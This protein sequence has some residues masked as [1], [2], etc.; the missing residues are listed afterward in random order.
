METSHVKETPHLITEW[1]ES[2]TLISSGPGR[3]LI[4]WGKRRWLKAPSTDAATPSF[5]FPDFF[6][7]TKSP[8]FVHEYFKEISL[9]EL[10]KGLLREMK[11]QSK[12]YKWVN[13]YQPLF[14]KTFHTL[15]QKF[16]AREI[17][18]A[19]PF[20]YE[21]TQTPM[22]K[23]QR[24]QSLVSVLNYCMVNPAYLYGF[25]DE[26]EGILGA[27]PEILFRYSDDNTLE[28]MACAGTISTQGDSKSFLKDPKELHEHQL[29]VEGMKSSLSPFGDVKVDE[30][31]LLKLSRLTHLVTPIT[32]VLNAKTTF[33]GIVKALHPTPAV[34]TFPRKEGLGWLDEYQ[35]HIDRKRFGAPVG[36]VFPE[37]KQACCYVSIRNI[38]WDEKEI[39]IGAGCGLVAASQCAREWAEI[40]LKLQAIKEMLAL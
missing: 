37:S 27:T 5:Y 36:L 23:D 19:V 29:V 14:E 10:L 1:I 24:I 32:V 26:Q 33:E 28:T 20:V 11:M 25:W 39:R 16:A 35:K 2:G 15:Q 40:N 17:D 4:G 6:L 34:G 21:K 38:Q 8:W 13:P 3:L 9:K 12:T 7:K 18:K 30:I 22:G 31:K